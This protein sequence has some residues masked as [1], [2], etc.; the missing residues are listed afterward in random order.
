VSRS[1]FDPLA[2]DYDAGRPSYP[3]GVFTAIER[4]ACQLRG[5]VVLDVGAGTGIAS[6]PPAARGRS[7]ST[8][9]SS[10]CAAPGPAT[11]A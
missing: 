6:W 9:V 11:P 7:R 3:D 4:T 5:A 10:C 2:A 1:P 8:S